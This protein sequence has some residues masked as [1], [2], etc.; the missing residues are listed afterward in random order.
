MI[1]GRVLKAGKGTTSRRHTQARAAPS[2]SD[3]AAPHW[4]RFSILAA[5]IRLRL[6]AESCLLATCIKDDTDCAFADAGG[7]RLVR[8]CSRALR[9]RIASMRK[10][11][12]KFRTLPPAPLFVCLS[13]PLIP[14]QTWD[15]ETMNGALVKFTISAF[16]LACLCRTNALTK[17]F[18]LGTSSPS[19]CR[20][21]CLEDSI[22]VG[23]R[24][25]FRRDPPS[26]ILASI[27]C[28]LRAKGFARASNGV[29]SQPPSTH[30]P[31][32]VIS[33]PTSTHAS[34]GV[35]SQPPSP[36]LGP[37]SSRSANKKRGWAWLLG[38]IVILTGLI[39]LE[40]AGFCMFFGDHE[41]GRCDAI[42]S[43]RQ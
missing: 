31:I 24:H 22:T 26:F 11:A 6:I 23:P 37:G 13:P 38:L 36:P 25:V 20:P 41:N 28:I 4:S 12:G 43:D 33:Q 27:F 2:S 42:S 40:L 17:T 9:A 16:C 8:A 32:G 39:L 10:P 34:N 1:K 3:C 7:T 30:A 14:L 15:Y 21:R 19:Q 5:D 35:A 18:P 29:V